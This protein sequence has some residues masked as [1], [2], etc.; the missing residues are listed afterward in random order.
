MF[1][2]FFCRW[3]PQWVPKRTAEESNEMEQDCVAKA[4]VVWRTL[5]L[6]A[7]EVW[8]CIMNEAGYCRK[9]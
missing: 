2:Y 8:K 3:L 6:L 9:S 5:A 1:C 4:F 7:G